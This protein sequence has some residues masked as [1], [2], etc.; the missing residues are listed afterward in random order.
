MAIGLPGDEGEVEGEVMALEAPA[1]G[2]GGARRAE[3]RDGIVLG[4]AEQGSEGLEAAQHL[5]EPV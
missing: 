2:R 5:L 1:P 4:I 3:H